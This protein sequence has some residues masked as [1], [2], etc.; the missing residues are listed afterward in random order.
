[1]TS[2]AHDSNC[3]MITGFIGSILLCLKMKDGERY[4]KEI[5]ALR[6]DSRAPQRV[7]LYI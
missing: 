6:I 1:M 7:S 5:K 2:L 3:V 4:Y